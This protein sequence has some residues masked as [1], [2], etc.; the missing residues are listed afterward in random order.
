[1]EPQGTAGEIAER[2]RRLALQPAS[3]AADPQTSMLILRESVSLLYYPLWLVDYQAGG[4]PYRVVVNAHDGRRDP[5]ADAVAAAVARV[6][7][8]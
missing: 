5:C 3:G 4:R 2:G 8:K 6:A 7:G 1:M